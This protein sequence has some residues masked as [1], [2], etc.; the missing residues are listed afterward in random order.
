MPITEAESG[1]ST[2]QYNDLLTNREGVIYSVVA[3]KYNPTFTEYADLGSEHRDNP[4]DAVIFNGHLI[5]VVASVVHTVD[6]STGGV[7]QTAFPYTYNQ[8]KLIEDGGTLYAYYS[9]ETGL[10]VTETSAIPLSWSAASTVQLSDYVH[11]IAPVS[12]TRVHYTLRD[13]TTHMEQLYCNDLDGSWQQNA[14][15]IF[16]QYHIQSLN[17]AQSDDGFD[18][19][20]CV[21]QLPGA[22]KTTAVNNQVT[23]SIEHS[24][25]VLGWKYKYNSWSDH[26]KIEVTDNS[27][28]WRYRREAR[29]TEINGQFY[30]TSYSVDGTEER[31]HD[32]YRMYTSKDGIHWSLGRFFELPDGY[33]RYGAKIL[34]YGDYVYVVQA[35]TVYRSVSTLMFGHSPSSQQENLDNRIIE[36]SVT[37]QGVQQAGLSLAN[38]DGHFNGHAIINTSNTIALVHTFGYY[39][40]EIQTAITEV[41][42]VDFTDDGPTRMVKLVARDHLAWM[43]DKTQ[44]E[45]AHYWEGHRSSGDEY[46]DETGTKYGGLRHTAVQKGGWQTSTSRLEISTA[47]EEA[48]SFS[49]F[50]AYVWNGIQQ[51]SFRLQS[52]L[53]QKEY[54]G[55][56]FRA[57]D[58]DNCWGLAYSQ[59]DDK[60]SLF[61]RVEG[62]QTVLATSAAL[63][64]TDTPAV[65]RWLR[66]DFKYAVIKC[67]YSLDGINWV[68]LYTYWAPGEGEPGDVVN[69]LVD[70]G[71]VGQLGLG[72]AEVEEFEPPELI[73]PP[74]ITDVPDIDNY[75]GPSTQTATD[76]PVYTGT[77]GNIAYVWRENTAQAALS[78]NFDTL[79]PHWEERTPTNGIVLDACWDW[80]SDYI[81]EGEGD[82]G[83]WVLTGNSSYVYLY[84]HPDIIGYS[85]PWILKDQVG[86]SNVLWGRVKMSRTDFNDIGYAW[87]QDDA[88]PHN[89]VVHSTDGGSTWGLPDEQ[90]VVANSPYPAPSWD[91]DTD[92]EVRSMFFETRE[93]D[94]YG[95]IHF[96]SF[97]GALS[98][99]DN[100]ANNAWQ[101]SEEIPI[102]I[103]TDSMYGGFYTPESLSNLTPDYSASSS[104][105]PLS[106]SS[107][108]DP[109][110]DLTYVGLFQFDAPAPGTVIQLQQI[111]IAIQCNYSTGSCVTPDTVRVGVK[112]SL[113]YSITYTLWDGSQ[114]SASGTANLT[115]GDIVPDDTDC[116]AGIGSGT[117]Q[118]AWYT[119][120]PTLPATGNIKQ[121]D[122]SLT[123]SISGIDNTDATYRSLVVSATQKVLEAGGRVIYRVSNIN[124][125]QDWDNITPSIEGV[126][127]PIIQDMALRKG[128]GSNIA[129]LSE[130]ADGSRAIFNSSYSGTTWSYFKGI[131]PEIKSTHIDDLGSVYILGGR[132]LDRLRPSRVSKLGDLHKVFNLFFDDIDDMITLG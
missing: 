56:L 42:A 19:I 10:Y 34:L 6:L 96:G 71:Y 85:S 18:A 74:I 118:T 126:R 50:D 72:E 29:V 31:K 123:Q 82:L 116:Q 57:M 108:E 38:E 94:D 21:T 2:S 46:R 114:Y 100:L 23:R 15:D 70:Y 43:M 65:E 79:S 124:A 113:V 67:Y 89:Y 115:A 101:S 105:S 77:D 128:S 44:S 127:Y 32:G 39:P 4:S 51:L 125:G 119:L 95:A 7:T 92:Y 109:K 87:H 16:Y 66:V 63:G 112:G 121:I 88:T 111:Q 80:S 12:G 49:T 48:V 1:L 69:A 86:V 59:T 25:C 132:Y 120:P 22:I 83:I 98:E 14:S 26:V 93:G 33:D 35:D 28:A 110:D 47:D 99:A 97:G 62:E 52:E 20:V 130:A 102:V 53:E 107:G 61:K 9:T 13:T 17:A 11:H 58:R 55:I 90:A 104:N 45:Q 24:I 36:Y 84:Y 8:C 27:G 117:I 60:I 103:S 3:H 37:F 5:Q 41:D 131:Q 40:S 64:W 81:Q 30:A 76:T 106:A 68:Y 78:V 73:I 129:I 54:A 91:L 122:I 75:P